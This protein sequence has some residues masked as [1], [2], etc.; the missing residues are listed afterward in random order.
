MTQNPYRQ[1]RVRHVSKEY[2]EYRFCN[3][4]LFSSPARNTS[5]T[6]PSALFYRYIYPSFLGNNCPYSF[7]LQLLS[8]ECRDDILMH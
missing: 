2:Q 3:F 7:Y 4:G 8:G 5:P 6:F 1:G